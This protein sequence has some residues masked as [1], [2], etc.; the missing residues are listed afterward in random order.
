MTRQNDNYKSVDV[1]DLNDRR[2]LDAKNR[3]QSTRTRNP[4]NN[5]MNRNR[6]NVNDFYDEGLKAKRGRN[7]NK[8]FAIIT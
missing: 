4:R 8:E 6:R 1:M 3:R 7:L 5:N 2:D